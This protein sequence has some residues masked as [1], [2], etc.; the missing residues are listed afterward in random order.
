[1][2]N[3]MSK[4]FS[5]EGIA[6]ILIGLFLFGFIKYNDVRFSNLEKQV[7]SVEE[8]NTQLK[9]THDKD[10]KDIFDLILG[11]Q[12]NF[13]SVIEQEKIKNTDLANQFTQIKSSVG[14]LEK[15]SETDPELLKKYSKVY[16]LNEHY[17]PISL[18][19]IGESY[20][21]TTSRNYE[22]HADVLPFLERMIDTA[23]ADGFG[24]RAQSA[25]RSFVTQTVL[26]DNYKITYGAG[27]NSF[28]ADQGYSEHQLGTAIDFTTVA[29]KGALSGFEKTPEYKWLQD[30]AYKFGFVISYPANNSY[31]KFEPW[32]WRF[33][34]VELATKLHDDNKY[35][36]DMDQRLIDNYLVKIFEEN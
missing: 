21:G 31:Y 22:I 1:M 13:S 36:Y 2:K 34:G 30:N 33:V 32:H 29:T 16:F 23:G 10:V 24:L 6:V 15:L 11:T 12:S 20:R 7:A 3:F 19:D 9:Q 26:K 4:V 14:T 35:F 8:E 27:A 5:K 18:A 25:Y 17:V 28:S